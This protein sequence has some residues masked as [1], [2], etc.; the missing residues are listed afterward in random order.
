MTVHSFGLFVVD[1]DF[2]HRRAVTDICFQ[3][4]TAVQ[5]ICIDDFY[6]T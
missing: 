6:S 5:A 2:F 4:Q 3:T 1:Y